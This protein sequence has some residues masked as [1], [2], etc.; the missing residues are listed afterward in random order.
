MPARFLCGFLENEQCLPEFLTE[1][2]RC[3]PVLWQDGDC[4]DHGEE[5]LASLKLADEWRPDFFLLRLGL[6]PVPPWTWTLPVPIVA[7]LEDVDCLWH[8][9]LLCL[10]W[11]ALAFAEPE[12]A[13]QLQRA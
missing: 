9:H 2:G 7:V 5:F 10:P 4:F 3:R 13:A 1:Q 6:G 12:S 8:H 11:C